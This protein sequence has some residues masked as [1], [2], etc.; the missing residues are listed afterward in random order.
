MATLSPEQTLKNDQKVLGRKFGGLY[1]SLR[2]EYHTLSIK[3][4]EYRTLFTSGEDRIDLL[5]KVAPYFFFRIQELMFNDVVLHIN[6]MNY[7]KRRG[8]YE[9]LSIR[10]LADF[11]KD[12]DRKSDLEDLILKSVEASR[13]TDDVRNRLLAHR[14]YDLFMNPSAREI[15]DITNGQIDNSIIKIRDIFNYIEDQYF[16]VISMGEIFYPIGN[17]NALLHRLRMNLTE[18]ST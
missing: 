8:A 11:I 16:N 14:S 15:D 10:H 5:N 9:Y 13:F 4:R 2:N 12:N 7:E 17:A 18:F 3:W 6:R 1:N